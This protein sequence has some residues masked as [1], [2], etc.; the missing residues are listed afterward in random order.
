MGEGQTSGGGFIASGVGGSQSGQVRG[1]NANWDADWTV[2]AGTTERGWE[3]EFAIPF[4]T[5]RYNPGSDRTW[6]VNVMRNIRRKN[7]QVFLVAGAARLL[8]L[9]RLVGRQAERPQPA[10]AAGFQVHPLRGRLR[11]RRQD[12]AHEPGR[13]HGPHRARRRSGA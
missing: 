12:A 5:L 2:R 10:D 7:E 4:K 9:P 8:A 11:Q 6:G 13:P 3:A 1:F